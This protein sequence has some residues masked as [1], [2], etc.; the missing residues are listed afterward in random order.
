MVGQGRT[1]GPEQ[2]SQARDERICGRIIIVRHGRPA[3]NRDAGPRLDWRGYREWWSAYEEGSLAPGQSPPQ[4]L[5]DA[6]AN[7]TVILSSARPRAIETARAIAGDRTVEPDPAFN[8]AALPPPH[9]PS[10]FR[11]LPRTWNKFARLAWM[12]GHA[13]GEEPKQQAHVRAAAAACTLAARA[14]SE[15][16]VVL[17]AHGWFNRMLRPYLQRLGWVCVHD[18]GDGYWSYRIYRLRE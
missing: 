7:A 11:R 17:A 3:L 13:D 8:E 15:G 4:S 6:A 14:K 12:F 2:T 18:G 5:L 16:D 10:G 1:P 9:L